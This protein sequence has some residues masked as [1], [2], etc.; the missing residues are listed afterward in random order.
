[1]PCVAAS[2][3]GTG[4]KV[5]VLALQ[6]DFLEHERALA[7]AGGE[8]LEVRLPRDL[9]QVAGLVIPGGESTAIGKLM[10]LYELDTAI[11]ARVA[12]GMPLFGTCAGMILMANDIADGIPEQPRLGVMD[13]RVRRNAFGRQR[14]S[15]ETQIEAPDFGAPLE[16][17]FIR[18]PYIE[19]LGPGVQALGTYE[20]QTVLARQG[21]LLAAAFHPELTRDRRVHQRFLELCK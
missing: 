11:R 7:D 8:P 10:M 6:G 21:K 4:L 18:A 12:E 3:E 1:M 19:R 9:A 20:G 15:F 13:I 5:G 14:D 17:V 2:T 16:G